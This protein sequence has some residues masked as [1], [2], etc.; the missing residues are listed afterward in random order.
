[1]LLPGSIKRPTHE[2]RTAPRHDGDRR[3]PLGPHLVWHAAT[4]AAADLQTSAMVTMQATD[5]SHLSLSEAAALIRARSASPQELT[6]VYLRRIERLN[7]R[8]N[9]YVQVTAERARDDARRAT[10]EIASGT[11]FCAAWASSCARSSCLISVPSRC[12]LSASLMPNC[13]SS[14]ATSS[15]PVRRIL[16]PTSAVFSSRERPTE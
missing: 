13:W 8:I 5:V 15:G 16:A 2:P 4:V 10:D 14:T 3:L 1:M 12:L 6:D 11:R 9:A 7:P